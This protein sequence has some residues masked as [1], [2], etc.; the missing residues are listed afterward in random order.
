MLSMKALV[1]LL[2]A[3]SAPSV[4]PRATADVPENPSP[5]A[6]EELARTCDRCDTRSDRKIEQLQSCAR[7]LFDEDEAR[8][9]AQIQPTRNV[10]G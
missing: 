10:C 2:A 1:V 6:C 7:S 4:A 5:P 8:C 9:A 3:L